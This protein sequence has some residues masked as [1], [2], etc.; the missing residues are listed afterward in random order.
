M[1]QISISITIMASIDFEICIIKKRKKKQ[2][3]IISHIEVALPSV[4][5]HVVLSKCC[6][7]MSYSTGVKKVFMV[8]PRSRVFVV[9]NRDYDFCYS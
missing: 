7:Q 5:F 9:N 2:Y 6:E 8:F 3:L 4:S 1:S